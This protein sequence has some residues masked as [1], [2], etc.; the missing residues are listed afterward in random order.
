MVLYGFSPNVVAIALVFLLCCLGSATITSTSIHLHGKQTCCIH[1]PDGISSI[2]G[3]GGIGGDGARNQHFHPHQQINHI[4]QGSRIVCADWVWWGVRIIPPLCVCAAI[5][6]SVIY[7]LFSRYFF[8]SIFFPHFVRLVAIL[9]VLFNYFVAFVQVSTCVFRFVCL[10][11]LVHFC[12]RLNLFAGARAK[13][14]VCRFSFSPVWN[15]NYM[16]SVNSLARSF[17]RVSR[18]YCHSVR[19]CVCVCL[20]VSLGVWHC[21]HTIRISTT[22]RRMAKI[23]S[24]DINEWI[25][26]RRPCTSEHEQSH[27]LSWL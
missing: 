9:L 4:Y 25:C 7:G 11:H 23:N 22:L 12:T 15:M 13:T 24:T 10:W 2:G 6:R 8:L 19:T 27:Q 16:C 17:V 21:L 5:A 20:W 1:Q 26:I 14:F 18:A 3:I